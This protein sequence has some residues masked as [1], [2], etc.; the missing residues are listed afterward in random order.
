[1]A[2]RDIDQPCPRC[3]RGG[4]SRVSRV[5]PNRVI[6]PVFTDLNDIEKAWGRP[7]R[8]GRELRG[9]EAANGL[10]RTDPH[11]TST[12]TAWSD[13]RDE[14]ETYARIEREDGQAAVF[15]YQDRTEIQD[16]TGWTTSEYREWEGIAN[17]SEDAAIA[18]TVAV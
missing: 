18:G 17:A 7:I 9:I 10:V 3:A 11:S 15:D 16:S 6:G 12:R 13:L 5:Y 1:M 14:G 4:Y 2:G 8:D